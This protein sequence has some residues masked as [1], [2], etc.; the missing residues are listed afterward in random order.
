MSPRSFTLNYS[1][2]NLLFTQLGSVAQLRWAFG[3]N[4]RIFLSLLHILSCGYSLDKLSLNW[5]TEVSF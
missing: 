3:D 4:Q 1:N 5:S 2:E